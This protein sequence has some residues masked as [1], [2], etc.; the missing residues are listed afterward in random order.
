MET[1]NR[2]LVADYL[3]EFAM[4]LVENEQANEKKAHCFHSISEHLR[5]DKPVNKSLF[6]CVKRELR[7]NKRSKE[8]TKAINLLSSCQNQMA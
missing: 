2:I 3:N 6:T 5:N 8:L 4:I 7:S 1:E